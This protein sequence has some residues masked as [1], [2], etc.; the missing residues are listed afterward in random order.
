MLQNVSECIKSRQVF[1]WRRPTTKLLSNKQSRFDHKFVIMF[2]GL[3]VVSSSS[4]VAYTTRDCI[5]PN[6]DI[7]RY[8]RRV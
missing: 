1:L 7:I 8:D 4:C 5:A 2:L 3:C 6:A